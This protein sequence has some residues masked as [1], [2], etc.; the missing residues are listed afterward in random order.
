M[1]REY[2]IEACTGKSI[3]VKAGETI[4][5]IDVEGGQVADFLPN[6]KAVLMSSCRL[7]LR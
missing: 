1:K 6:V 2:M 4:T 5:V 7:E 3:D